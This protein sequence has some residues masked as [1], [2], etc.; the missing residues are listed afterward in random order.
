MSLH[1]NGLVI[2]T[3][4]ETCH[5]D[6]QLDS[7]CNY[8]SNPATKWILSKMPTKTNDKTSAIFP[9]QDC[10]NFSIDCKIEDLESKIN[11]IKRFSNFSFTQKDF[12]EAKRKALEE[13]DNSQAGYDDD[14]D[15]FSFGLKYSENT[16]FIKSQIEKMTLE[17]LINDF[18]NMVINSQSKIIV[19]GPVSSNPDLMNDIANYFDTMDFKFK[20]NTPSQPQNIKYDYDCMVRVDNTSQNTILEQYTF[21]LS[22]NVKDKYI[23]NLLAEVLSKK[24]FNSIREEQGLAYYSGADIQE[25]NMVGCISLSTDSSCNNKDDASKILN[26]YKA[27]IAEILNGKITQEELILAKNKIKGSIAGM[28]ENNEN[29]NIYLMAGFDHEVELENISQIN[30][31]IDS[32]TIEDIQKASNY[33]FKNKPRYFMNVTDKTLNDNEALFAT[34]GKIEK[35]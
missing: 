2:D 19:K 11:T 34:L 23:F 27:N 9:F 16:E 4:D 20:P 21:P 33:V 13:L 6:W 10:I 18:N 17:D 15:E 25:R 22:G 35:R 26:S 28:F 29:I 14:L 5:I 31:I 24:N 7:G 30:K 3:N 12:E 32:I 1:R 8:S